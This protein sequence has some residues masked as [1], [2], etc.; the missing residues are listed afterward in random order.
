M[1][2]DGDGFDDI[3][4]ITELW[5]HYGTAATREEAERWVDGDDS[6]EIIRVYKRS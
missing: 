1:G 5:S 3:R 6:I 2:E 4:S